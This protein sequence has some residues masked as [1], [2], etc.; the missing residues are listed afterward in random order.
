MINSYS[1]PTF[2]KS[3]Y[4]YLNQLSNSLRLKRKEKYSLHDLI[5]KEK[6][7][8]FNM[9][10]KD[11]NFKEETHNL[12]PFNKS[13]DFYSRI[14]VNA[15]KSGNYLLNIIENIQTKKNRIKTPVTQK[16]E[17]KNQKLEIMKRKKLNWGGKYKLLQKQLIRK[18]NSFLNKP[19]K[20][21]ES[22]DKPEEKKNINDNSRNFK[23]FK[24]KP[25]KNIKQNSKFATMKSHE[26]KINNLKNLLFKCEIGVNNGINLGNDF[27]KMNKIIHEND[28]K[29]SSEENNAN[30]NMFSLLEQKKVRRIDESISFDKYR[31]LE[32]KKMNEFKKDLVFKVSDML[33]YSNR[34][35]YTKKIKGKLS[36]KAFD[37]YLDDLGVINKEISLKR[38]IEKNNM[39]HLNNLLDDFHVGKTLLDM[40]LNE[41]KKKHDKYK[42]IKGECEIDFKDTDEDDIIIENKKARKNINHQ[43]LKNDMTIYSRFKCFY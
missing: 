28:K 36:L 41:L 20:F 40:K 24:M 30:V 1:T 18:N 13:S 35:E 34:N 21:N 33:A 4:N 16:K 10:A 26:E 31:N 42:D 39:N 19:I 25:K 38:K 43:K 5:Q 17:D 2:L 6:K 14:F 15:V 12:I 37:L 29:I 22:L 27:E 8:I 3:K 9:L 11:P 23:Y 32:E 7:E